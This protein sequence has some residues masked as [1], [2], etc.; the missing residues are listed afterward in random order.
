MAK[1]TGIFFEVFKNYIK[2]RTRSLTIRRQREVQGLHYIELYPEP[3]EKRNEAECQPE[4]SGF[5]N[6][7]V[8]IVDKEED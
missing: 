3:A 2:T 6:E 1:N 7:D 5:S 8:K 4:S